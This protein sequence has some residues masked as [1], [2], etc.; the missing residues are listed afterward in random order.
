MTESFNIELILEVAK[1]AV[2]MDVRRILTW[3]VTTGCYNW[4]LQLVGFGKNLFV[5]AEMCD[6]PNH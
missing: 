4:L 2:Y 5:V 3:V 1:V 6:G